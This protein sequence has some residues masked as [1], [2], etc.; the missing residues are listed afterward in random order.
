MAVV[1]RRMVGKGLLQPELA[2]R[3]SC[4]GKTL[5]EWGLQLFG[6]GNHGERLK[7]AEPSSGALIMR[8]DEF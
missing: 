2:E 5:Q 7:H 6:Q 3:E 1:A 4:R 8:D